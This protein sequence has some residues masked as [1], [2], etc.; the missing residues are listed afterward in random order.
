MAQSKVQ[1]VKRTQWRG[2]FQEFGNTYTVEG[3]QGEA[4][5]LALITAIV[6]A[7]K[8]FHSSAVDFVRAAAWEDNALLANHMLA[9]TNLSGSGA[10]SADLQMFRECCIVLR[11]PLPHSFVGSRRTKRY[12]RKFFHTIASFGYD[13]Q[14]VSAVST[15][16]QAPVTAMIGQLNTGFGTQYKLVA[17]NGAERTGPWEPTPYLVARNLG[18]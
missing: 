6:N 16:P 13:K 14:G 1:V 3:P 11:A 4:D 7:E 17:P 8:Q 12:L 10:A 15:T 9:S 18:R 5:L 2:G